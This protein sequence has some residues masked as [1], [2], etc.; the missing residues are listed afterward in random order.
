VRL[1]LDS[2]VILSASGSSTGASRFIFD[3][4]ERQGWQLYIAEYCLE[5]TSR[6][7]PKF[8]GEASR[9]F[10]KILKAKVEWCA[11]TLSAKEV[12]VFPKAK[13]KP[14]LL[15]ALALKPDFLLTLDRE[16]F[17][18]KLGSQFYGIQIR[19]PGEFLSDLR[20]G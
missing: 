18:E 8:G 3:H 6:N 19:T 12:L 20:Q 10:Q 9:Y 17:H 2:S 7:A 13:D 11:D 5:E 16:D 4:A 1:F 14:V 15:G